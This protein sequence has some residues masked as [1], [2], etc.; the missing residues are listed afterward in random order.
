MRITFRTVSVA[1]STAILAAGIYSCSKVELVENT[2]TGISDATIEQNII[3][4]TPKTA[5][6]MFIPGQGVI[7]FSEDM[8]E[9]VEQAIAAG[10]IATKAAGL[11]NIEEKLGVTAMERVFPD[12]GE[13]EARTRKEGLHRFYYVEFDLSIELEE[14]RA[15]FESISG[16]ES[17]EP[18]RVCKL[19][20]TDDPKWSQLWGLNSTAN[21]NTSINVEKAWEYTMGDPKV[22]V[23]VVDE[24]IQLDHEDLSWNVAKQDHFN[25]VKNNS[26]ISAGNHGC[27]VSGTIAGIG[28][29]GVGV[30]GIAGGDYKAKKRGV[31]LL[32]AEVFE[33]NNSARSFAN[34]IKWGADHGAV[35]SQ[36]SWGNSYDFNDNGKLDPDEEA[37]AMRD[38]IDGTTKAGIDYFIKYAGCDNDG[39]QNPDS[40]MKGGVVIFAAGN[41]GIA[42]GVPG[43]YAPV[44]AVGAT[45]KSG[46]LTSFSDYGD[47]VDIC[48]PGQS[49]ISS[50]ANNGYATY[51]GTSMACPHVSGAAALLVS[52]FGKQGFTNSD[53]EEMLINGAKKDFINYRGL[54]CGPYLDV[55]GSMEYGILKYKRENNTAPV[56]ETD[57]EGDFV[58]KHWEQVDI[59]FRIFDLDGDRLT[60]SHEIEGRGQFQQDAEIDTVYHFSM[61]CEL[62]N[63]Y[64]PKKLTITAKDIIDA[65]T[66]KEITYQVLENREPAALKTLENKLLQKGASETTI[67][68]DGCFEDPDEEKLK[69]SASV[70]PAGVVTASIQDGKLVIKQTGT[71]RCTV[72]VT[73]RDHMSK[74]AKTS[75]DV[76][77]RQAD[78]PVDF[79]PNPVRDILHVRA[80]QQESEVGVTIH[81]VT[82]AKLYDQK[83]KSSAFKPADIDM[84]GFAPGEYKLDMAIDGKTYSHIIVKF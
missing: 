18:Q 54:A 29:N 51:D 3:A 15:A 22:I 63:D 40:P 9:Q 41:D 56:I 75:F 48:A 35:I 82:G 7:K 31:T 70:S 61:L 71:G 42:N 27:H 39:N 2:D 10:N 33:G 84:K 53:L 50:V 17:F 25:F 5:R 45:S 80:G 19:D 72:T 4:D 74:E 66:V 76:L 34:A 77:I 14:A 43:N 8:A 46:L 83:V 62:V 64:T 38:R 13:Y 44:I 81:S 49:I 73:A 69:L 21:P 67:E 47:W 30:I 20:S 36:N 57:Y 52:Y 32:S 78:T 65:T 68:L 24:G 60:I 23:C 6:A 55:W 58:F 16:V 79:Y 37:Y 28:N 1:L 26:T 11:G 12:A 59:P